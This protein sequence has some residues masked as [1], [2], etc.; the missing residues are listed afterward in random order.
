MCNCLI[1]EG[2][3]LGT[4]WQEQVPNHLRRLCSKGKVVNAEGKGPEVTGSGN[5]QE[6]DRKGT[7]VEVSKRTSDDVQNR[8]R[9]TT[10]GQA[11]TIPAYGRSGIRHERWPELA[12][13][14]LNGT[15]ET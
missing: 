3:P 12:M 14:R 9:V 10:A 2:W 15:W 7:T 8:S 5:R 4:G 1:D 11:P 13:R 6:E